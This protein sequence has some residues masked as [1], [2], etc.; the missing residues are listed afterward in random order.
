M[1][2]KRLLKSGG[3]VTLLISHIDVLEDYL[4]AR[5]E[6]FTSCRDWI[7]LKTIRNNSYN[8]NTDALY[9][10]DYILTLSDGVPT[11]NPQYTKGKASER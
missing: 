2:C 4:V 6:F 1:H 7:W 8:A 9:V 3:A 10:H 11:F 5:H